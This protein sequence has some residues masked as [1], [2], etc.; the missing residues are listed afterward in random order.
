MNEKKSILQE[1]LEHVR[2]QISFQGSQGNSHGSQEITREEGVT[3]RE[4]ILMKYSRP[5][6]ALNLET[7]STDSLGVNA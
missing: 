3:N 1:A 7:E 4:N 6:L 2:Y 5:K